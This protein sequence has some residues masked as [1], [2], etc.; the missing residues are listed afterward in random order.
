MKKVIILW[1]TILKPNKMSNSNFSRRDF[2]KGPV[3]VGITGALGAGILS[4]CQ[5]SAGTDAI[6]NYPQ[7]QLNLP[8]LLDTAPAGKTLRAGVIGC[9]GRG[10]GAALDFLNAGPNLEVTALADVF[11]D[12]IDN[13]RAQLK[14]QKGVEIP[15][16]NCFTGFDAYEKLCATD[17]DVVLLAAP[18]KFRPEHFEA[19][20]KARKH[21]FLEKPIAVDPTGVRSIMASAKMAETM[22]L[23]VVSGTHKRHESSFVE[24]L[25]RVNDNA[26]G[27][28]ISANIYYNMQR[29]WYRSREASWS[30]M[31]WMIRDWV[32][33]C[34]LSGDHI[35]E[36]H[37]HNIDI[38]NWFFGKHPVK[39][40]G[41]GSKHR[42]PTGDQYDNFS[43][44]FTLDDGRQIHSMCRQINGT[45]NL[46]TDVF[47]G[48]RGIATTDDWNSPR[49]L[50]VKG[51]ILETIPRAKIGGHQQEQIDFVTCIRNNI[52][53]NEAEDT[54]IS[55]MVAIM[56]RVSAYTGKTV[57]YEEMMNSEMKLGPQIYIMG[58]VNYAANTIIPVPGSE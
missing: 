2:I 21:V 10:T 13:C 29:L 3:A 38:A 46:V 18:P 19:A 54:A 28:I 7:R 42:R 39:A 32:N 23:K 16:E 35:V 14:E 40:L 12:R 53:V 49:I 17:V 51:N 4:S 50:D 52:P 43:V 1:Q 15:E 37:V 31:E 48:T 6:Y 36:Q 41:F 22:D 26:I 44:D 9:G 25:K 20:V 30:D 33:W 55:T 56:G 8:P 58:D 34:W 11:K 27:E 47:H 24:L 57:T 5:T 45:D